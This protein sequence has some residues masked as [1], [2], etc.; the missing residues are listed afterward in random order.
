MTNKTKRTSFCVS[1]EEYNQ[2]EEIM[3][4]EKCRSISAFIRK[5]VNYY[6]KEKYDGIHLF[7]NQCNQ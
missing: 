4:Q 5:C 6:I 7:N 1:Q 3:F 2:W